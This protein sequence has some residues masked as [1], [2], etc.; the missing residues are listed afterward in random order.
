MSNRK[1]EII[2][3][4][5]IMVVGFILRVWN[6]YHNLPFLPDPDEQ[7]NVNRAVAFGSGDLNP[8]NFKHPATHQYIL[9]ILF[10]IYYCISY[11]VGAISS[12]HDFELEF[13]SDPTNFYLIARL[14]IVLLGTTTLFLI[15]V[16]G[17]ENY[18][19]STGLISSILLSVS[20]AH[21]TYFI[22]KGEIPT[23]FF[24]C[25]SF[26]Y[27][28][29]VCKEGK[30]ENYIKAGMLSGL[31]LGTKYY[32]GL[33]IIPLIAS[34][35]FYVSNTKSRILDKKIFISTSVM[36]LTFVITNPYVIIDYHTF[37]EHFIYQLKWPSIYSDTLIGFGAGHIF[38]LKNIFSF[39]L[40]LI[41]GIICFIG[42]IFASYIHSKTDIIILLFIIPFYFLLGL[43][44]LPYYRY[45][46]PIIP[47][48]VLLGARTVNVC[49]QSYLQ[50]LNY[51]IKCI[52]VV[53]VL[54][55]SPS[56]NLI[57]YKIK[58]SKKDVRIAA[59]EW[60]ETNIPENSRILLSGNNVSMTKAAPLEDSLNSLEEKKIE[61]RNSGIWGISLKG[62]EKY[63]KLKIEANKLGLIK[64][65][66]YYLTSTKSGFNVEPIEYYKLKKYDYFVLSDEI[67]VPSWSL[68][69]KKMYPNV[70]SFYNSLTSTSVLLKAFEDQGRIIKIYKLKQ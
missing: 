27:I 34:H 15:Y 67:E 45:L 39:S 23:T 36:G 58:T 26:I 21:A 12:V 35:Y 59:K 33:L 37:Y 2:L 47:L 46:I 38:Y 20:V 51:N 29:R 57:E 42:V 41:L 60:I 63:Y 9:F 61:N 54:I 48:V 70:V 28:L 40:G 66:K 32:S 62:L 64:S 43:T 16:I 55:I 56:Y 31:A 6:I 52:C 19:S 5:L 65:K 22:P 50:G 44:N 14:F 11:A 69:K 1:K 17:K 13:I 25:F 7:M 53:A 30:I 24:I 10:G 68:K 4:C 3:L 8:H 49:F 18:G